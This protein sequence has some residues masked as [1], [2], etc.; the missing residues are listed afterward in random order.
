MQKRLK[1]QAKN[2]KDTKGFFFVQQDAKIKCQIRKEKKGGISKK[3]IASFPIHSF[4]DCSRVAK[5][6]VVAQIMLSR[7]I[8][9]R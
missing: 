8:R 9:Y 3:M 2:L 7:L 4:K 6:R 5:D 1:V